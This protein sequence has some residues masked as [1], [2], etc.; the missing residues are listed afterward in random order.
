MKSLNKRKSLFAHWQDYLFVGPY[1]LIFFIFTVLPV[2]VAICLS[3]TYYNVLEA[4][5]FNGFTNYIKMLFG[6]EVFMQ[7]A[8]NTLILAFATGPGG[9]LLSLLLAWMINELNQKLR[10]LFVFCI[11]APSISGNMFVIWKILFS[12]DSHGYING[13]LINLHIID[14]PIYWLTDTRYMMAIVIIVQ[15]WM[16]MGT[17]FLSFVA[18]LKGIDRSLIEAGAIDGIRNRWQELW[19]V[20]LPTIRP[21]LVFGAVMSITAAFSIGD[22]TVGL[23]G[24]PSTDYAVHTVVNHLVDYGTTRFDMGYACA[25]ATVLFLAMVVCNKIIQRMLS[26]VGS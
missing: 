24:N 19:Y 18:G 1:F 3:F 12:D 23:C 9:Y 6:D 14:T 16:S 5:S 13:T 8:I 21:Q 2:I 17:G 10:T 7:A 26:K 4:P 15:L 11:Y 25:M 22:I 20:I